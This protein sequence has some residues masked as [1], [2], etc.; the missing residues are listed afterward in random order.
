[1]DKC[2]L[3]QTKRSQSQSERKKKLWEHLPNV[4]NLHTSW[5]PNQKK[6]PKSLQRCYT[7]MTIWK[8]NNSNKKYKQKKKHKTTSTVDNETE[9]ILK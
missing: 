1:M 8:L 9:I 2:W 6:N 5:K 7:T 3:L 4:R